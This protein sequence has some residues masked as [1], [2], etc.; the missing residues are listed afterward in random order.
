[1]LVEQASNIGCKHYLEQ[2][3]NFSF[4]FIGSTHSFI[5]DFSKQEEIIKL[6][7]PKFVL[8][9]SLEDLK[10]DS[11]EKF[12]EILK[13]RVVSNMTSFDEV[14]KLIELCFDK[15]INLVGIDLHNFGLDDNLQRKVKNQEELTKEDEGKL[16]KIIKLREQLHLSRILEYRKKT[17]HTIIVIV[18]CW[19]LRQGS[20]L[21]RNLKNYKII[22]PVDKSGEVLLAPDE[23]KEIRYGEIVSNGHKAEN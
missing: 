3:M 12:K 18:G 13:K 20:L 4:I 5:D 11:E 2:R 23:N 8:S 15:K 19:H 22:A 6:T 17:T 9:E 16:D 7:D 14:K 1:M 21:R 10:L